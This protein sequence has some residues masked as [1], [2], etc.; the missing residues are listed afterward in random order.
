V[1]EEIEPV[2]MYV[3]RRLE[4]Y[5]W[6]FSHRTS[7]VGAAGNHAWSGSPAA[8]PRAVPWQLE[9]RIIQEHVL[10]LLLLLHLAALLRHRR[11]VR[12]PA[13]V[14]SPLRDG[15]EVGPLGLCRASRPTSCSA[16]VIIVGLGWRR[17]DVV[18]ARRGS[19]SRVDVLVVVGIL[20][21]IYRR[22][23]S[24]RELGMRP[25]L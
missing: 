7:G 13:R 10:A 6:L 5:S 25:E 11:V 19:E 15:G 22:R 21:R 1:K 2:S 18:G 17:R 23:A 4:R 9:V 24:P 20:R 16:N 3:A 12:V 14:N 8:C